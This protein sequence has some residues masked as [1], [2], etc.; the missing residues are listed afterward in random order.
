[1]D[2]EG[3]GER[4]H[5]DLGRVRLCISHPL[6]KFHSEN[7]IIY[8]VRSWK[9]LDPSCSGQR[10]GRGVEVGIVKWLFSIT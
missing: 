9:P 2:L 4:K 5:C 1:M 7:N 8:G 6:F 3:S 10:V